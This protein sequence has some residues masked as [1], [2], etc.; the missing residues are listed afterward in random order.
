MLSPEALVVTSAA[1]TLIG[2]SIN[3]VMMKKSGVE[4][5]RT[6]KYPCYMSCYDKSSQYYRQS[7]LVFFSLTFSFPRSEVVVQ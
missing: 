2:Y 5:T 4:R 7:N 3:W 1:L 6:C